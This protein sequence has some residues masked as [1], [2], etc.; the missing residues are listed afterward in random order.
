MIVHIWYQE[1]FIMADEQK[2]EK[3]APY[4][5]TPEALA[6]AV[7]AGDI[8]V[9]KDTVTATVA[10]KEN[11]REYQRKIAITPKGAGILVGSSA[12]VVEF[13][14]YAYDLGVRAKE[15]SLLLAALEGPEKQLAKGVKALMALGQTEEKAKRNVVKG[16]E[17]DAFATL[18]DTW[19][20]LIP[21][22]LEAFNAGTEAFGAWMADH[23]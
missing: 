5:L 1:S 9:I 15:R 2:A 17:F 4:V 16:L 20:S 13:F 23:E 19:K 7:E 3:P 18:P 22:K 8:K 11:E 14:N 10:G 12:K 21:S 6:A